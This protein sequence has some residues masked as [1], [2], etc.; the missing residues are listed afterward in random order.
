MAK[1]ITIIAI[2]LT[3]MLNLYHALKLEEMRSD[4]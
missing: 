1:L 3:T 4:H 2:M